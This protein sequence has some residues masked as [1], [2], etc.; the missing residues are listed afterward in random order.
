MPDFAGWL[1]AQYTL[2]YKTLWILPVFVVGNFSVD[3]VPLSVQ[4]SKR[5]LV[6]Y[7]DR[8]NIPPYFPVDSIS[9]RDHQ[10]CAILTNP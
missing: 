4:R 5:D 3:D 8:F 1:T 9:I 10:A 7:S 6:N 2:P